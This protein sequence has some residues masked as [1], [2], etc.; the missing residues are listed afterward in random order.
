MILTIL[1]LLAA[2][3]VTHAQSHS[4]TARLRPISPFI[5]RHFFSA[6]IAERCFMYGDIRQSRTRQCMSGARA[7]MQEL[8]T[9]ID[10]QG[11]LLNGSASFRAE[12]RQL[13]QSRP[14][15]DYLQS[16]VDYSRSS[17]ACGETNLWSWTL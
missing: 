8:D 10:L 7:M 5:T 17:R 9:D 4:W 14:A 16:L 12:L 2:S 13:L 11:T 6:A 3:P 1:V 15:L